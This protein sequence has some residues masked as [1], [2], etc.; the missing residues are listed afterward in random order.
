MY[1]QHYVDSG[2]TSKTFLEKL[3]LR[4]VLTVMTVGPST[5]M[6]LEETV[7]SVLKLMAQTSK[8]ESISSE[9]IE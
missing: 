9:G 3:R 5:R 7:P 2:E 8:A 4:R 1:L 6:I